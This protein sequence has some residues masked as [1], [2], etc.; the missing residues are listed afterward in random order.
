MSTHNHNIR[1]YY[2]KQNIKHFE[3]VYKKYSWIRRIRPNRLADIF[4][5]LLGPWERRVVINVD[6]IDFYCDPLSH[7]GMEIYTH[8]SYEADVVDEI[9]KELKAGDVFFDIGA[10]E[11]YI[12]SIALRLVGADGMVIAAEP[13]DGIFRV[14][15]IN[16]HLNALGNSVLLNSAIGKS[17]S[18]GVMTVWPMSNS[19]G[20]SL[21]RKTP[22][23]RTQEIEILDFTQA[24]ERADVDRVDLLKIDV[25]GYER[26]VV[27]SI[28]SSPH[29][30]HVNKILIDYHL[31]ILKRNGID[32]NEIHQSIVRS[33]F[34]CADNVN[35]NGYVLYRR[36]N[37][38]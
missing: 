11:G 16:V 22:F 24:F 15:E 9:R 31:K 37:P 25:E 3:L 30:A 10:N 32:P 28:I 27:D 36:G 33:G 29:H 19:G 14:L 6:G 12:T 18:K 8:G 17:C 35:L 7:T 1:A 38:G 5:R 34:Q 21:V 23:A 20:S 13:Q 2:S 26:D 4:H